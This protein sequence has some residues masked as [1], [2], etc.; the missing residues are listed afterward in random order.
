M[1]YSANAF[2]NNDSFKTIT[3]GA[4]ISAYD[5]T[6]FSSCWSLETF[7]AS[8]SSITEIGLSSFTG[9]TSLTTVKLPKGI[10]SISNNAF[11]SCSNLSTILYEGTVSEWSNVYLGTNAFSGVDAGHVTC[12]DGNVAIA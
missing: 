10:V 3:L 2:Q 4:N 5:P 1:G 6:A 12:S 11:E 7:D 9:L 8:A